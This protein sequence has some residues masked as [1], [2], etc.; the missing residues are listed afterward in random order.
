MRS[1]LRRTS[2]VLACAT[3]LGSGAGLAHL[4]HADAQSG[5]DWAPGRDRLFQ[6]SPIAFA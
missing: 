4:T 5:T 1:V 2:Q 3:A 6:D